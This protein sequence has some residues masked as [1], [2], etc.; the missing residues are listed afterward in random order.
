MEGV[1]S[2]EI[3]FGAATA[4]KHLLSNNYL[5]LLT[6]LFLGTLFVISSIDKVADPGAFA[7]SIN[8]YKLFPPI[9]TTSLATVLGWLELLCGVS[10]L[11]GILS[12]GSSFLVSLML[13]VFTLAVFS[14]LVRGLDISCGCF[15]QDPAA[16]KIG[17]T[18]IVQNLSL[19]GLGLFLFFSDTNKFT[20]EAYFRNKQLDDVR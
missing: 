20:V 16:D 13:A 6:R 9:L 17:W 19:L 15:T 3:P 1:G 7:D 5:S 4:M 2:R 12:R 8:N 11:F 10:L 14:A 18:K